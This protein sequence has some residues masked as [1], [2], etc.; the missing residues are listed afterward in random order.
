MLMDRRESTVSSFHSLLDHALA[1]GSLY[2]WRL[3][4]V[5]LSGMLWVIAAGCAQLRIAIS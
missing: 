1:A 5:L 2:G 4:A 3:D